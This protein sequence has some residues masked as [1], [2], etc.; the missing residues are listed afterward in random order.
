MTIVGVI[1]MFGSI[2]DVIKEGGFFGEIALFSNV[3]RTATIITKTEVELLAISRKDFA[4]VSE[5][6]D[7]KRMKLLNFMSDVFP[8]VENVN[9]QSV[10]EGLLYLI[11]E[12]KYNVGDFICH[13]GMRS[14]KFFVIY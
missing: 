4:F 9:T 11:D 12:K 10:R 3:P 2:K 1:A 13:E 5:N 7:R 6:Y 8:E 14:D